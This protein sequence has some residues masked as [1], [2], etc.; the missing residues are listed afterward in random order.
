[1]HRLTAHDGNFPEQEARTL[2]SGVSA[3]AHARSIAIPRHSASGQFDIAGKHFSIDL[4][5]MT[6]KVC[7]G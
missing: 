7:L 3:Y 1:M 2:D 4:K 5:C 6:A